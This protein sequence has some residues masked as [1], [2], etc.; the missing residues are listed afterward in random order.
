MLIICKLQIQCSV[1][2]SERR[3][4]GPNFVESDKSRL[5]KLVLQYKDIIENKITD[6][7]SL[8][9]KKN[10][11]QKIADGYNAEAIHSRSIESLKSL[12]DNIKH[13]A[14]KLR[15]KERQA[16]FGTGMFIY[17]NRIILRGVILIITNKNNRIEKYI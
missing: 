10:C 12:W 11:W 5:V 14:R 9:D 7:S 3:N 8:K 6:N 4:R 2:M 13:D 1:K 16:N 17:L 15:A